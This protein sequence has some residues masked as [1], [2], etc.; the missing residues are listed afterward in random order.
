ME[1][2]FFFEI[3][4]TVPERSLSHYCGQEEQLQKRLQLSGE[5]EADSEQRSTIHSL[6]TTFRRGK[7]PIR[8][9]VIVSSENF[10]NVSKVA[11]KRVMICLFMYLQ[12]VVVVVKT[13]FKTSHASLVY[14]KKL[15]STRGV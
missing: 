7:E 5:A 13:L 8:V 6:V 1:N 4:K 12:V 3:L 14:Y 10:L 2:R 15:V 11:I 9:E